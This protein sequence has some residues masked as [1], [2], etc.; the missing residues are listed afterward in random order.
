MRS[1]RRTVTDQKKLFFKHKQILETDDCSQPAET[2]FLGNLRQKKYD[3][4]TIQTL[5][6]NVNQY[7]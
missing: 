3:V 6:R 2:E 7:S 4:N 1:F 5:T